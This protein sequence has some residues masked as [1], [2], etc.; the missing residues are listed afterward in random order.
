MSFQIFLFDPS[1]GSRVA[2]GEA[3]DGFPHPNLNPTEVGFFIDRLKRMRFEEEQQRALR[4]VLPATAPLRRFWKNVEGTVLEV[5]IYGSEIAFS[6]PYGPRSK[7][8]IFEALQAASELTDCG[9]FAMFDPQS[10]NW[11]V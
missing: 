2:A 4:P 6:V 5:N 3:L 9:Q 7:V 1:V 8:A 11:G 10:G